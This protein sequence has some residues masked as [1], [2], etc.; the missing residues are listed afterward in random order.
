MDEKKESNLVQNQATEKDQI[1]KD[2]ATKIYKL[3]D[4]A[5]TVLYQKGICLSAYAC[6]LRSILDCRI[7]SFVEYFCHD[8][9][10]DENSLETALEVARL[11]GEIIKK[12][13]ST[14]TNLFYCESAFIF[15]IFFLKIKFLFEKI[16][17]P[18]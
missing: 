14:K 18:A 1:N 16:T 15:F 8:F 9:Y 17:R 4:R 7:S 12:A 2:R 13:C 11:E 6:F 3:V 5:T 10:R